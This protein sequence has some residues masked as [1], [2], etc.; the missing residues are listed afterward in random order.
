MKIKLSNSAEKFLAKALGDDGLE[1]LRK[2]E[3]YKI[4]ANKVL[5]HEEIRTALQIVPRA[6]LS[7]LQNELGPMKAEEG[8][9]VKLPVEPEAILS[10]TKFENDVYSGDI[11]QGG[12]IVAKFQ[13][14]SM[15]GIGLVIMSAFELYDVQQLTSMEPAKESKDTRDI[16]S[17]IDERLGMRDLISQ[18]VDKKLAERDAIDSLIRLR[19]TQIVR[20]AMADKPEVK[21]VPS[22]IVAAPQ[23]PL[24]LKGFLEK[25]ASKRNESFNI[26]IEKNEKVNCPDCGKEIFVK[27][28]YSGCICFGDDRKNK[29]YIRKTEDGFSMRFPKSWDVE[30]IQMLLEALRDRSKK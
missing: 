22:V 21:V 17:I 7:L 29:I 19:L 5:D 18:V 11:R 23:K 10:V 24:A 2:F 3:L 28:M 4:K 27:G 26:Q 8:K 1:Q 9:E 16:Q 25:K 13:H 14:R 12:Q 15:P 30:N 6:V 20:E